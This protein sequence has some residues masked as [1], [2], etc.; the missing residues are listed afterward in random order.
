MER[1][2]ESLGRGMLLV[3]V[4]VGM[5]GKD[6]MQRSDAASMVCGEQLKKN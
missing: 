3:Q 5:V 1:E 6:A 4:T 2:W